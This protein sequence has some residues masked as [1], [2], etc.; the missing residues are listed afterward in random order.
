MHTVLHHL[1]T[2]TTWGLHNDTTTCHSQSWNKARTKIKLF[3]Y[4]FIHPFL[5]ETGSLVS[6]VISNPIYMEE[7]PRTAGLLVSAF[8]MLGLTTTPNLPDAVDRSQGCVH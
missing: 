1:T 6:Q 5:S 8:R 2:G 4:R 7:Q 3:I